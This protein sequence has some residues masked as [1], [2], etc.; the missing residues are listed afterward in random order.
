MC[1]FAHEIPLLKQT[2]DPITYA[3][4]L[5]LKL[6]S[7]HPFIDGNGQCARLLMNLALLQEGYAITIIPPIVR[8]DYIQAIKTA[9][10]THNQQP[11]INFVSCMVC[12]AQREY[13][14]LFEALG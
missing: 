12:E 9:Q 8:S 6:V 14:R 2:H 13:L 5:H 1:D 11:F 7:I 3:A 10:T 4:L